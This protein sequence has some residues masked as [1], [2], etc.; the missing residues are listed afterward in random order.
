MDSPQFVAPRTIEAYLRFKCVCIMYVSV[1]WFTFCSWNRSNS[2]FQK[3]MENSFYLQNQINNFKTIYK[4]HAKIKEGCVIIYIVCCVIYFCTSNLNAIFT[5]M[6]DQDFHSSQ[7]LFS[8]LRKVRIKEKSRENAVAQFS[9][10]SRN[11]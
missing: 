3:C 2:I 10:V 8:S 4:I 9:L 11:Y 6:M 5:L 7:S 1:R